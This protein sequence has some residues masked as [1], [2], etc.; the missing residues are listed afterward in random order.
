MKK[1]VAVPGN[2]G[3]VNKCCNIYQARP[4]KKSPA[5]AKHFPLA[6]KKNICNQVPGSPP[7]NGIPAGSWE[8]PR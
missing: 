3:I 2:G 4:A 5:R 8:T 6:L 7:A 1:R